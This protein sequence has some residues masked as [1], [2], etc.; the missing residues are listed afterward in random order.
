MQNNDN[1][2][3]GHSM[4]WNNNNFFTDDAKGLSV[5]CR[6]GGRLYIYFQLRINQVVKSQFLVIIH[7]AADWLYMLLSATIFNN[8]SACLPI[9]I[10]YFVVLL[11]PQFIYKQVTAFSSLPACLSVWLTGWLTCWLVSGDYPKRVVLSTN[12]TC[13][14]HRHCLWSQ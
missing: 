13:W 14:P 12:R 1:I 2:Q 11:L 9:G 4:E 3:S 10:C 5:S 8:I 7:C 6:G